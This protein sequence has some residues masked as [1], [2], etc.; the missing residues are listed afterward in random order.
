MEELN[1]HALSSAILDEVKPLQEDREYLKRLSANEVMR[2]YGARSKPRPLF[3][4]LWYEGELAVMFAPTN[5]GKSLFAVQIGT[6]IARGIHAG[7]M[8]LDMGLSAPQPVA[9]MDFENTG[10][11]WATRYPDYRFPE[12]LYRVSFND[13]RDTGKT[14]DEILADDD[15]VNLFDEVVCKIAQCHAMGI[16]VFIIDNITWLE[17]RLDKQEEANTLIRKLQR[18]CRCLGVSV[19]LISHTTKARDY[20]TP[21]LATDLAGSSQ[22]GNFADSIFTIGECR[23]NKTGEDVYIKQLKTR[24]ADKQYGGNRV[25]VCQRAQLEGENGT[26]TG[27][28][29]KRFA[30]ESDV[31]SLSRSALL[32]EQMMQIMALRKEGLT[33]AEIAERLGKTRDAIQRCI[34]KWRELN[35][36][37]NDE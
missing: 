7:Q 31:L 16:K 32:D 22:L 15:E 2:V 27:L 9:L 19:L 5:V 26:F 36:T 3:G 29:Y 8:P 23:N 21:V 30:F 24:F 11:H 4:G 14:I 35:N 37:A 10:Y 17:K 6:S 28:F 1:K 34:R 12:T 20:K 13:D 25:I 33:N 18:L